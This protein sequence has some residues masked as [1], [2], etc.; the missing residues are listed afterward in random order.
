MHIIGFDPASFIF[1]CFIG[2]FA[3]VLAVGLWGAD[4][5]RNGDTNGK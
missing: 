3:L 1:G 2:A 5:K 4:K